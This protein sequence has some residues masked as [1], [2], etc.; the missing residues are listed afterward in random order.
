MTRFSASPGARR[1]SPGTPRP[2]S[3]LQSRLV[4]APYTFLWAPASRSQVTRRR[5]RPGPP[6]CAALRFPQPRLPRGGVTSRAPP[7]L[8]P[9]LCTHTGGGLEKRWERRGLDKRGGARR[10]RTAEHGA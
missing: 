2:A 1:P 8:H 10:W 9:R 6:L 7:R 4:P 5:P 3:G